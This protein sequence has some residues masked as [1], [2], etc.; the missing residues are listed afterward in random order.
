MTHPFGH[1]TTIAQALLSP[2]GA[3][4]TRESEKRRKYDAPAAAIDAT[5]VP[6]IAD[7]AGAWGDAAV[8]VIKELGR[9]LAQHY[10]VHPSY[11]QQLAAAQLGTR[12]MQG[13]AGLLL[14]QQQRDHHCPVADDH[15]DARKDG[16]SAERR[17]QD[18]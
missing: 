5:F 1:P 8:D 4:T 6:L 11:A 3:T 12:V 10:G 7:T 14:A 15:R 16:A 18:L 17:L 9:R 2:G 13:V